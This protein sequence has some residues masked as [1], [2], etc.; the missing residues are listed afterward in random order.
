[1]VAMARNWLASAKLPPSFWFYAVRHAAEV[2]NYFPYKLEDGS[3]TTPFELVHKRKPDLRVL[4]KMFGL[5]AVCRERI[6]DTTLNKF[7]S[8]SV[9]M[10]AVGRCPIKWDLIL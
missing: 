6:G 1:M 7:D 5:A 8:Q 9:L 3:Y 10:I 4:F 2:C